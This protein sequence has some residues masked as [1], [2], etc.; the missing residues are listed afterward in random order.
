M[1]HNQDVACIVSKS[2]WPILNYELKTD[3]HSIGDV[4]LNRKYINHDLLI[5]LKEY[6]PDDFFAPIASGSTPFY[7][8]IVIP[9]SMKT[10]AAI[11]HGYADN[12]IHRVCDIALK[13]KRKLIVVPRETPMNTIHL[14]NLH[15]LSLFGAQ[16]VMPIPAFYNFP[17]TIDD[18]IQFV[19]GRVLDLLNIEH[20]L[21]KRW[22][23]ED[24]N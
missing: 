21:Y 1:L 12:L 22:N 8:S 18:V 13:E 20:N 3:A 11:T 2:A 10:L 15:T 4:L 14:A 17:Q 9:C 6:A 16:V 19:V 7:A 24:N 5:N 23:N